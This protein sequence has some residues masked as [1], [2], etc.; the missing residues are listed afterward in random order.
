MKIPCSLAS[1]FLRRVETMNQILKNQLTKLVLETILPWIKCLTIVQLRIR[2][3]PQKDIGLSPYEMFY[4]LPYLSSVTDVPALK[5]KAIYSKIILGLSSTFLS[6]R[7]NSLLAQASLLD[8]PIHPH[9]PGNYVLIKTRKENKVEPAWEGLFFILLTTETAI[10]SMERG[11][12]HH[13]QVKKTPQG[14]QKENG[15]CFHIQVTPE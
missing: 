4:G 7:K 15:L 14:D 6:L 3:G 1:T 9:Q 2:T 5:P 8:F 12:T 10:R 11:W 13:T